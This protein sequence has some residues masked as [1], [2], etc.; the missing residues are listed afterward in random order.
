MKAIKAIKKPA[1]KLPKRPGKSI[2]DYPNL[3]K[4]EK[5]AKKLPDFSNLDLKHPVRLDFK[6]SFQSVRYTNEMP[7]VH[8]YIDFK[9]MSGNEILLNLQNAQYFRKTELLNAFNELSKRVNLPENRS[10][11]P[12]WTAHPYCAPMFKSISN[13]LDQLS[14]IFII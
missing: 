10:V 13:C 12:D 4:E 14:V 1:K 7:P 5:R 2:L 3:Y 8:D 11:Y 6:R 9:K